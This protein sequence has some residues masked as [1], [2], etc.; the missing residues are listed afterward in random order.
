MVEVIIRLG[1]DCFHIWIIKDEALNPSPKI[2]S[3][4]EPW[5]GLI[6]FYFQIQWLQHRYFNFCPN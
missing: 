4:S 5:V 3:Q 2:S 6:N 1:L